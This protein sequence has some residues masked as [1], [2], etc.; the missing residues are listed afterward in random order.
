[1]LLLLLAGR[2][3]DCVSGVAMDC[4]GG[5]GEGGDGEEGFEESM[6]PEW[7]SSYLMGSSDL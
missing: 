3:G 1:M 5:A 6:M 2:A 7:N 4:R